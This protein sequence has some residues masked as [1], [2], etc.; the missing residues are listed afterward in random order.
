MPRTP[1]A[2]FA[3]PSALGAAVLIV[4]AQAMMLPFDPKEHV[5]T[6]QEPLFRIGGVIYMVGFLLLMILLV[7]VA[8]WLVTAAGR[9]GT[10]AILVAIIGTMMLGGDLWFETF[11][12]PWLSDM[13]PSALDTDPTTLLALGGLA[14]YITFAG[15][16]ALVGVAGLRAHLFP[17]PIGLAIAVTGLIGFQALLAPWAVPLAL[18]IGALGIWILRTGAPDRGQAPELAVDGRPSTPKAGDAGV[19]MPA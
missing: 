8:D 7:S 19:G 14:S 13:A 5:A 11:A 1:L 2:K 6:T 17:A 10:V 9:L 4:I 3:G 16:W 12:V 15:G 18:S